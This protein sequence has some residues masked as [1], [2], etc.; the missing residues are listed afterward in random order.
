MSYQAFVDFYEKHLN[1]PAGEALRARID[2]VKDGEEFCATV[3]EAGR[4]AGFDFSDEDVRQVM[5]ASE[6]QLAR[7]LVE[8]SGELTDEQLD[9]VAGGATLYTSSIPTV[10]ISTLPTFMG[11]KPPKFKTVVCPW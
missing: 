7:T 4:A 6:E 11:K 1:S 9:D 2:A 10:S 8:A 5:R 3:A